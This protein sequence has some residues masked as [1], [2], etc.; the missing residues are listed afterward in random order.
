MRTETEE[1]GENVDSLF[2]CCHIY[3]IVCSLSFLREQL[4]KYYN[5]QYLA[6]EL[7]MNQLVA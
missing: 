7:R 4:C 6:L 2:L 1:V 3:N 5:S